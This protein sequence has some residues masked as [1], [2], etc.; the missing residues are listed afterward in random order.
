MSVMFL[1]L[2][3]I[4]VPVQCVVLGSVLQVFF[5]DNAQL[6]SILDDLEGKVFRVYIKD[7]GAVFFIGFKAGSVWVHPSSAQR[8]DVK[9]EST[10]TGFARLSFAK[11]D[12]DALVM[13]QVLKLSGDSQ[14]ML[15]F[16]KLLKELDLDW[17][18]ELRRAF[19]D[20][21]GRKVAKA[22][23][24]LIEAEKTLRQQST[25]FIDN[26]LRGMDTPSAESLQ[27]WQAGVESVSRK[28][29][30]LQRKLD[31]LERAVQQQTQKE[32]A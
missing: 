31:K 25:K 11:E 29:H 8:P 3:L 5:K 4:P 18:L 15:L 27:L 26:A 21:F 1:P 32:Q 19:G 9:I 16:Q 17:E 6:D 7:T 20:F 22:A 24:N 14:A 13:Q 10:M 23:Y 28:V 2:K 12:P 30:Q